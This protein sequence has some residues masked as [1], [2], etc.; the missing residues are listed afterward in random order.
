VDLEGRRGGGG[1]VDLEVVAAEWRGC[2]KRWWLAESSGL[3]QMGGDR[4]TY[5]YMYSVKLLF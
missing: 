1:G 4:V 3:G 5:I 2:G